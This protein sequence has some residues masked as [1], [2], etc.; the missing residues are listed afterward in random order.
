[1]EEYF[2]LEEISRYVRTPTLKSY[3]VDIL[4]FERR[5]TSQAERCRARKQFSL[6]SP[7]GAILSSARRNPAAFRRAKS[8]SPRP[9][10]PKEEAGYE[11]PATFNSAIGR[12]PVTFH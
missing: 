1:M 9:P 4:S 6:P 12:T 8:K 11:K 2:R 3:Q 5:V 7:T 10:V